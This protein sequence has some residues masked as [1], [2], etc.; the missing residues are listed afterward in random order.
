VAELVSDA[1]PELAEQ[2]GAGQPPAT[3]DPVEVAV[4]LYLLRPADWPAR[5]AEITDALTTR[6]QERDYEAELGR[7]RAEVSRLS[8]A[9]AELVRLRDGARVAAREA[10]AQQQEENTD[11]RRRLRTAQAELREARRAEQD[12]ARQLAGLR[13][14]Q[15]RGAT[16]E[17]TELRKARA[18]IVALE[19]ELETGRRSSRTDR[20]HD[21]ARLWVL[22]ETLTAAAA[23][24][25]REL[26]VP[27][28][29]VRP[30]EL[31]GGDRSG[32]G[33]RPSSVDGPLL[34]RLLDGSHVHL[35]VDGY[36]VTKT[37]YPALP[38]ADQR[39]R[40]VSSLGALAARTGVEITVAFDGTAAPTG[41]A[42]SLPTPRGVRVLFSSPGQL[43]DDLIRDL[44]RAEPA[45]RTVLVASS[46]QAVAAS[47]R[48]AGGWPASAT[49][50]LSRLERG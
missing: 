37:G 3:A 39:A 38:L 32:A 26:D 6:H 27:T 29:A 17:S 21:D 2:V 28:P 24:L 10:T 40:L 35:I 50:L 18:R 14:E 12:A 23:G 4:L 1:V 47:V 30:A 9:N 34:D 49:V 42:A 44:L 33:N 46:D 19:A 20:D 43:A 22:L 31:V 5:L 11:L 13:A 36:N 16:A 8:T 48:A 41:A 25:R 7:L 45:G 15:E